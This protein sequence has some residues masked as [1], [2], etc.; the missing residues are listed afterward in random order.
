MPIAEPKTA[1]GR[2]T[3]ER[4]VRAAAKV[5]GEQGAAA[6]SLDSVCDR[7]GASRS[8]LY[9]YFDDRADLIRAVV[10][11][12]AD[13][14][15]GSQVDHFEH[16]DTWAG[17]EAWCDAL[18]STQE[19]LDAHGGCPIGSLVGQL[20][21]LDEGAREALAR[22]F[23]RWEQHLADGLTRMQD[24]GKLSPDADPVRLA[25]ATMAS[26]QG[27]LLLTQ[28]RRDPVQLRTALDGALAM[29]RA[30]SA[31]KSRSP[32]AQRRRA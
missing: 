25:T 31:G 22:S 13:E 16:L 11:A 6:M 8:Q 9:H 17:I 32:R 2:A 20:A 24:R 10:Y 19:E 12:T 4:I 15:L 3:R 5:V 14:V 1:K 23:D 28:A 18:V 30:A 7:A 29:L 26:L 27:G 21:E